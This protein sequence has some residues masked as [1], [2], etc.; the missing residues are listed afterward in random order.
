M[1]GPND[2]TENGTVPK[3]LRSATRGD[4]DRMVEAHESDLPYLSCL[5][6]VLVV[7]SQQLLVLGAPNN[8]AL[9]FKFTPGTSQTCRDVVRPKM[10]EIKPGRKEPF[11]PKQTVQ[12]LTRCGH[13]TLLQ[14]SPLSSKYSFASSAKR[15]HEAQTL[16]AESPSS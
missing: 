11:F 6:F 9:L 2:L 4:A 5:E 1:N 10:N 12:T 13:V 16:N 7:P 14:A 3:C 8:K 15:H